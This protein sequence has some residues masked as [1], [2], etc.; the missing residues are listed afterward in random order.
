MVKSKVALLHK[1]Q[2]LL[3]I[4]ALSRKKFTV[5]HPTE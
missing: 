3:K 1:R 2:A 5:D 4:Q